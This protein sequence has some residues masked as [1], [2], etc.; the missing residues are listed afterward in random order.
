MRGVSYAK[1]DPL[2]DS[3]TIESA[4][5]RVLDRFQL[6]VRK[7]RHAILEESANSLGHCDGSGGYPLVVLSLKVPQRKLRCG[8][9]SGSRR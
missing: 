4:M 5:R 3:P 6:V 9:D 2:N 1:G 7:T 8:T